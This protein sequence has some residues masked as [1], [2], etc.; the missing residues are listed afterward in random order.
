MLSALGFTKTEI[1]AVS[2]GFG[3]AMT[4]IGSVLGGV[5]VARM[6]I[7][8]A[9]FVGGVLQA[10][11]NL[12]FAWLATVGHSIPALMLTI[13]VDNLAGGFATAA[14]VSYLASLC[15]VAYTA[16][17]YALLSSFAGLGR[18]TFAA[19]AGWLA[20]KMSWPSFFLVTTLAAIPGM[21]L[22]VY[23]MRVYDVKPDAGTAGTAVAGTDSD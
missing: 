4:L 8:K 19:M 2:K 6:G 16:T 1:A 17:Q 10:L 18:N 22:L 14:F 23:L 7:L 21:L 11:T 13:S 15:N 3:L 20:D 5:L 12:V 9:L